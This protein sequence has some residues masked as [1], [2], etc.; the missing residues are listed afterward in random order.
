MSVAHDVA[1]R[2]Q[3]L[4][5][6]ELV[7]TE[8]LENLDAKNSS[9]G[10]E[11]CSHSA[12]TLLTALARFQF[13][14]LAAPAYSLSRLTMVCSGLPLVDLSKSDS[15]LDMGIN[16]ASEEEAEW[17][18]L[19]TPSPEPRDR[20]PPREL[21]TTSMLLATEPSCPV[22]IVPSQIQALPGLSQQGQMPTG[23]QA[24]LCAEEATSS[25]STT[26]GF[27]MKET[28]PGV[29]TALVDAINW[30]VL[31]PSPTHGRQWPACRRVPV[32]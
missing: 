5:Q 3:A 24:P 8:Q 9:T 4:E 11:S 7:R 1:A 17:R 29:G 19:R 16:E 6:R 20:Y 13:D 26:S 10:I 25:R 18:R 2:H 23:N 21:C 14:R 31:V 22:V 28:L 30:T 27:S 15:D 32:A 12:R